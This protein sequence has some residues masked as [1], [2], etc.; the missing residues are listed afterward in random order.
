MLT[1]LDKNNIEKT[2]I[3]KILNSNTGEFYIGSTSVSFKKRFW[4]HKRL[5][6]SNKNP[7]I[8]LQNSY[9]KNKKFIFSILEICEK[10]KCIEREQYYID[11]LNPKYNICKIAGSSAGRFV[12]ELHLKNQFEAQRKFKD[13]DVIMMFKLYNENKKIKDIAKIF[14]C[15]PNNISSIINKS[16]KYI[17]VKNKYNLKI[18][19]KKTKYKG[20]Y[21]IF[22]PFDEIHIVENLTR[23]AKQNNLEPS[24][25]NRC[26]NGLIKTTK[27]YKV[28]KILSSLQGL[29]SNIIIIL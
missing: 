13:N 7:C 12:S 5:L 4:N 21:L 11:S 27:G 3:Y 26:A 10:E 9:N 25:L 2:G 24:N 15:K 6:E 14:N 1:L 29:V 8:F 17:W 16:K 18:E 20:K 19:N 28:K 23:Y 22:T